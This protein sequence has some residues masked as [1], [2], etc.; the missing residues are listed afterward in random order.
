MTF[1]SNRLTFHCSIQACM[2]SAR[3]TSSH[4]EEKGRVEGAQNNVRAPFSEVRQILKSLGTSE[5]LYI[6]LK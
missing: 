5:E 1:G 3:V 2:F 4:T 6:L